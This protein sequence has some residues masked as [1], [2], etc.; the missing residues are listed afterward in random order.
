MR[1]GRAGAAVNLREAPLSRL[2]RRRMDKGIWSEWG[3]ES[4]VEKGRGPERQEGVE[5]S[6]NRVKKDGNKAWVYTNRFVFVK[7]RLVLAV[8]E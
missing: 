6:E 3:D 8:R 5:G 7:R 1:G 2:W 4:M